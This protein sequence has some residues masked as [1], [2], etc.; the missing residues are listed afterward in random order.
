METCNH[1][2]E[3]TLTNLNSILN[4]LKFL[5]S[6]DSSLAVKELRPLSPAGCWSHQ[7]GDLFQ[8]SLDLVFGNRLNA[9]FFFCHNGRTSETL[10]L[11]QDTNG[12]CPN[13]V[14]ILVE[15]NISSGHR[16]CKQAN[17]RDI[18]MDAKY[19]FAYTP[20]PTSFLKDW[21]LRNSSKSPPYSKKARSGPRRGQRSGCFNLSTSSV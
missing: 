8:R 18:A 14:A 1:C 10:N 5:C 15:V 6:P 16:R 9:W 19:M 4:H 13:N 21:N 11:L 17:N 7:K 2:I 3:T 20:L 12:C